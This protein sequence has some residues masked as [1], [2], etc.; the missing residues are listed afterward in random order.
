M[1]KLSS[2]S[3]NEFDVVEVVKEVKQ[4]EQIPSSAKFLEANFDLSKY[5]K[6]MQGRLHSIDRLNS[7]LDKLEEAFTDPSVMRSMSN[8]DALLL[9]QSLIRRATMESTLVS[10][11]IDDSVKNTLI[12]RRLQLEQQ[13]MEKDQREA[14]G[15]NRSSNVAD[16]LRSLKKIAS[17]RDSDNMDTI[18]EPDFTGE[19]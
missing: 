13:R 2:K 8:K 12:K 10:K 4:E 17:A 3:M 19:A 7:L 9:Y 18:K 15:V 16:I 5:I 11:F 6:I 1:K 14:E